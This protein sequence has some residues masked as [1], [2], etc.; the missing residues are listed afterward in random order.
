M[1]GEV[2]KEWDVN[3]TRHYINSW[4]IINRGHTY[5]GTMIGGKVYNWHNEGKGYRIALPQSKI[6][7]TVI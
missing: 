1:G 2:R 6:T 4:L 3:S 7:L 5:R